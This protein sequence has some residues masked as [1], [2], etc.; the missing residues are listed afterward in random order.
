MNHL[1]YG[2][3]LH[4][5]REHLATESVDLIYLDPPFNSKRDYNLLF[6]APSGQQSEAQITAFEDSWHWGEQAEREF[7]EIIKGHN[8][9]LAQLMHALRSFLGQNDM[10]AYLTMMANRL[11]ELHRVLKPTGSLYLHCD[12]T[13]SHYLKIVLDG[14]FGKENFRNEIT[15]K[16]RVGM[17]SAVHESNRFGIITDTILFYAKSDEALFHPQY[18]RD[19]S[20]YQEYIRE[21]FTMVDKDGRRYQATSLVNPAYRPNLI[22]EYKGYKPPKN[23]WMITKEKME[24]WDKENRLYFPEN[25]EGRI[26]RKSYADELRGRPVQNL[27]ADIPEINSQAEERLGYPTQKPLALLERIIEAS[28]DEGDLVLDPFCGCGTAVHAA[29]NLNRQWIG[30]DVTHLAI[31]LIEKRLKDAF[32]HRQEQKLQFHIH[33]TP[34]DIAGAR[35][36]AT[37]SEHD[38]RYQ[39]QYWAVSLVEAQ[40]AQGGKKGADKGIDGLKFF[41]DVDGKGAHKAV[42]SVKSGKL[43][44]DDVR[45]LNHVR[46]REGADFGFLLTLEPPTKP[47]QADAA[48]AGLYESPTGKKY[49]RVQL[50]TI[51]NLLAGSERAE[52]P[53]A[54][55]NTNFKKAK[56]ESSGK[57][58]QLL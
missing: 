30:I 13:A 55:P 39:F 42:V 22:Y 52:H 4:V 51:E 15:W 26:R 18:N 12:P 27:W 31:S 37:L 36:L 33:G 2:D 48:T 34:Q 11:V 57:Q 9:D 29:E 50:L 58:G 8:T 6:K 41:Y 40:P 53:D 14:V 17:S 43:K 46:E 25:K 21:R 7:D 5:L 45:A 44:A 47:M 3:N 54:M 32:K 35:H 56:V 1:Y 28:S 24:Q 49:P 10:M 20:D 38:G 23:G 16:R 19:S